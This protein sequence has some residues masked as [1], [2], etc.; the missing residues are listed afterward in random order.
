[1]RSIHKILRLASAVLLTLA[2]IVLAAFGVF[3]TFWLFKHKP[4]LEA[5]AEVKDEWLGILSFGI[6]VDWIYIHFEYYATLSH[7]R[8]TIGKIE[9]KP[10]RFPAFE[11]V[12]DHADKTSLAFASLSTGKDLCSEDVLRYLDR[13]HCRK[14]P[15]DCLAMLRRYRT[16]TI[17]YSLA[18]R[19]CKAF[20]ATETK[21][22]STV[23]TIDVEFYKKLTE[24]LA[25]AKDVRRM[26]ILSKRDFEEEMANKKEKLDDFIKRHM[27]RPPSMRLRLIIYERDE[28]Q[29]ANDLYSSSEAIDVGEFYDFAIY[30]R[31]FLWGAYVF[32]Q[33]SKQAKF[34][35]WSMTSQR[36]LFESF[37]T[38]FKQVWEVGKANGTTTRVLSSSTGNRVWGSEDITSIEGAEAFL[39]ACN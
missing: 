27:E 28:I 15:N 32:A 21:R 16:T 12:H 37:E 34:L 10:L 2:G 30:S 7:L 4:P 14:R 5:L 8:E 3:V 18:G 22:P 9:N 23:E 29:K 25:S 1:M 31:R 11:F 33:A 38:W 13:S 26:L 24:K 36:N 39:A 35:H 20:Y 19:Q 17:C 6:I